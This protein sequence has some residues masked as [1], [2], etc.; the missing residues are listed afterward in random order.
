M[1]NL[2]DQSQGSS[3]NRRGRWTRLG[4]MVILLGIPLLYYGL[5]FAQ[6]GG[7]VSD[8]QVIAHRGGRAYAPENTLKAFRNAIASGVDVL[9]MDIQRTKDGALVV[10]H[11]DTVDRTTNGTGSVKDLTLEQ[12]RQL[13]AGDGEKIPTFDEVLQLAKTSG[14]R[15]FPEAKN[16]ELYPGLGV[17]MAQAITDAGVAP[18]TVLQSFDQNTLN[19]IKAKDPQMDVARLYGLWQLNPNSSPPVGAKVIS[20]MA[21]M[22]LINP[23]MIKQAHDQGRKVFVWFGII[24]KPLTMRLLLALGADGLIVDDPVALQKILGR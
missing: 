17:Q 5:Y 18:Q 8:P 6:G 19:E 7:R 2:T 13:D 3:N 12:I 21:E 24:E 9:E 20:P 1:D 22:A 16:P 11:D 14:T 23:W 4:C 15:I 10:I